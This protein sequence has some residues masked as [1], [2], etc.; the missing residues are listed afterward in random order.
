ME[1]DDKL[2]DM[3]KCMVR[4]GLD[5]EVPHTAYD[6]ALIVLKLLRHKMCK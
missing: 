3:K 2:P 1:N 6:D 5:G 4:A